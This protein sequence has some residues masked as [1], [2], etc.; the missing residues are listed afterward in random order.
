MGT[1]F[2]LIFSENHDR[3]SFS[4]SMTGSGPFSL[5]GVKERIEAPGQSTRRMREKRRESTKA[6]SDFSAGVLVER[7]NFQNLGGQDA[8]GG[9]SCGR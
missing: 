7:V 2:L 5:S 9:S 8:E 6:I 4:R 1:C 3:V